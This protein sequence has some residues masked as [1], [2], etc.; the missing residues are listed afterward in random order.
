MN[1]TRLESALLGGITLLAACAPSFAAY[2]RFESAPVTVQSIYANEAGS[3][4]VIF[5]GT[6]NA[7]TICSNN[8]M[9]LYNITIASGNS[10]LR[11]NKMAIALSAKMTGSRVVLDYYYDPSIGDHW[12][13]CYIEGIK[14]ID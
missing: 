2:A 14:I 6:L 12:D 9:Y 4:F 3:P 13:A 11:R 1:R 10:D 8:G 5:S 7:N